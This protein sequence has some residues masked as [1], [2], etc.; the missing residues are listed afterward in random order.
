[1][2]GSAGVAI[3]EVCRALKLTNRA[4]ATLTGFSPRAISDWR[5]GLRPPSSGSAHR[6]VEGVAKVDATVAARLADRLGVALMRTAVTAPKRDARADLE[7]SVYLAADTLGV[8]ARSLR[9]AIA[10]ILSQGQRHAMSL[11]DVYAVL[12]PP[13]SDAVKAR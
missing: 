3:G 11:D 2:G 13:M 12:V 1:M 8:P 4:L 10:H 9:L 7:S 6:L 5:H